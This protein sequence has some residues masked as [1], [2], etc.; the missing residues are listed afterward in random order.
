MQAKKPQIKQL[1]IF[2]ANVGRDWAAHE[3]ALNLAYEHG[4]HVVLIQEPWVFRDP[5]RRL[6]KHN[7]AFRQLTPIEDWTKRPRTL[8]YVRKH[9][10][11]RAEPL[12]YGPQPDRDLI[13]IRISSKDQA[14]C[15]LNLYNAPPGSV[16]AVLGLQHLISQELPPG[17]CLLAGD[18]NLYHLHWQTSSTPSAMAEPFLEWGESQGLTLTIDPDIPTRGRNTIDLVWANQALRRRGLHSEVATDLPPLAGHEVLDIGETFSTL[19]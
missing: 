14:I 15:I 12:S 11:I 7:P 2:Q 18:F 16:D 10:L 8:S 4:H 6:S 9:P 1:R 3:A 5:T 19:V 13:A 17:P